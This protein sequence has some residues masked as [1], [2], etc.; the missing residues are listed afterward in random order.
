M[1]I[2][3]SFSLVIFRL[4]NTEIIRFVQTQNLRSQLR[5]QMLPPPPIDL[6]LINEVRRH[7]A[8]SLLV[9]NGTIFL[10]SGG[11]SYFLAGKTLK[12]IKDMVD[13]QNQFVSDSSHELRTPLTSLKSAFEVNL[14]DPE[15]NLKQAKTLIHESIDEVNK[16]QSLSDQL[17]LLAQFQKPNHYVNFESI[18]LRKIILKSINQVKPLAKVKNISLKNKIHEYQI[19]ANPYNLTELFVILL[20]N[21]IKY[22][23]KNKKI[24]ITSQKIDHTIL[25][26]FR[27]QGVGIS[28]KDL[29][30][31]F[32]RFYRADTA[33]SKQGKNGFGLGLSIA[34]KIVQQHKG[35]INVTSIPG[36]G[37]LFTVK[38]P[39]KQL[40]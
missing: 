32:D 26:N 9:I 40:P 33:R 28:K 20:D 39:Q 15:F 7:L 8:N 24:E 18:S 4:I 19:E 21:A 17:L 16:L 13:E 6:D 2:S 34:Q 11:L 3:I 1:F 10:V 38:L 22:S 35:S 29:P 25:I 14:R 37:S 23:P 31:I 12:P 27:D 5:P 30:H 36:E